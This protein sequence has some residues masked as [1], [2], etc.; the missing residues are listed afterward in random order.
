MSNILLYSTNLYAPNLFLSWKKIYMWVLM[1]KMTTPHLF[2]S[3]SKHHYQE[4][5]I[6]TRSWVW[7]QWQSHFINVEN[8]NNS[9][10]E[11]KVE[12]GNMLIPIIMTFLDLTTMVIAL[13]NHIRLYAKMLISVKPFYPINPNHGIVVCE[14]A[15]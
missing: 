4:T 11:P 12:P 10:N 9:V 13:T 5:P 6:G 3:M 7:C 2:I 1:H 8:K 15:F 14:Q